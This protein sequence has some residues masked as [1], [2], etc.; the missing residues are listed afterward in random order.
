MGSPSILVKQD[1]TPEKLTKASELPGR[2]RQRRATNWIDDLMCLHK[3][4][5]LCSG[6]LHKW[7]VGLKR[8]GYRQERE[9]P[10]VVSNCV[11]CNVLDLKCSMWIHETI[12]NNVRSTTEDRQTLARS[13]E[14]RLKKGYL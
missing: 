3:V 11:D 5:T 2:P 14:K 6:C 7:L 1:W 10:Y 4:V 12:Y 9:F 8:Y 13:R